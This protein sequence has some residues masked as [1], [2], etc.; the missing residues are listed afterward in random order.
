MGLDLYLFNNK[1]EERFLSLKFD[2]DDKD[3]LYWRGNYDLY[4]LLKTYGVKAD[5][6]DERYIFTKNSLIKVLDYFLDDI[7]TVY[8]TSMKTYED[9][10]DIIAEDYENDAKLYREFYAV[11]KM[12]YKNISKERTKETCEVFSENAGEDMKDF[13]K[14]LSRMII[15]MDESDTVTFLPSY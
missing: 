5:T 10:D 13:I 7:M 9:F 15:N 4:Y 14:S 3:I 11:S 1:D 8:T 6:E 2:I 12:F